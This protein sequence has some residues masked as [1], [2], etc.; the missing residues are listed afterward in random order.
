MSQE[1]ITAVAC[2]FIVLLT[3]ANGLTRCVL[4]PTYSKYGDDPKDRD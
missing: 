2:L 3:L 1:R 4:P